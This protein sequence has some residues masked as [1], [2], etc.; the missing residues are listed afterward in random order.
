MVGPDALHRGDIRQGAAANGVFHLHLLGLRC[1]EP[2]A[3]VIEI[4]VGLNARVQVRDDARQFPASVGALALA[5][6]LVG[7]Q[8]LQITRQC[9]AVSPE[10]DR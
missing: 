9:S 1:G 5:S 6:L 4:D 2:L 10:F 8:P 7:F 3:L